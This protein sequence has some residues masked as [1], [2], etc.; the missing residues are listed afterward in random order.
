[1]ATMQRDIFINAPPAKVWHLTQ[2]PA[3]WN[4]IED[5]LRPE[6][7]EGSGGVGTVVEMGVIVEEI[8]LPTQLKVVEVIPGVSRKIEFANQISQGYG[9]CTYEN[10]NGRTKFTVR[11][12]F[13]LQGVG[14]VAEDL[15]M[16]DLAQIV[17]RALANLKTMAER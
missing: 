2:D 6:H 10:M 16:S 15:F 3:Q 12:E 11:S 8:K 9:L 17:E 4:L 14:K 5:I 13:S 1:M 7:T